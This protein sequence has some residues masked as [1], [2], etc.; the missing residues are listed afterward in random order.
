MKKLIYF[1]NN[2]FVKTFCGDDSKLVPK[3]LF[4]EY[5]EKYLDSVAICYGVVNYEI[6]PVCKANKIDFIYLD[7]CYFGNLSSYFTDKK[8]KKNFYRVVLNDTCL[9]KIVSREEDRLLKQLKYLKDNYN[10]QYVV[11]EYRRDGEN[12]LIIPP[13]GKV[14]EICKI[15]ED[16]WIEEV[17]VQVQQQTKY[18][19][20][21][22]ERSRTRGERLNNPIQ[23]EFKKAYAT[24]SFN[25]AAAIESLMFGVPTFIHDNTDGQSEIYSAARV[26]SRDNISNLNDRFFPKNRYEWLC[27]LA[28]G[29]FDREEMFG[30]YAKD[31]ILK[32]L[33]DGF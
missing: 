5:P 10:A 14:L 4:C 11:E 8:C 1:K 28:Y 2:D 29:Q 7:N 3:E 32:Q 21:V 26:L 20:M 23:E 30:G 24:V 33:E 13:S 6:I 9:R 16:E 19:P 12:I 27:H 25:S 18:N 31:F 17:I 22:R 15:D